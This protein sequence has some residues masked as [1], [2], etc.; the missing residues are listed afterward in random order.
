MTDAMLFDPPIG[1]A[2]T[3]AP[4]VRRI[5]APNPSPM[6]FRGTNTYLIG[7]G[8]VAVLD[9]GPADPRH[10]EAILAAA[11]RVSH[12]L[13]S[14]SHLDHSPLA[15]PLAEATGA[16]ILAYGPTGAGTSA[17]MAGLVD[18]G[19][20]EGVDPDFSPDEC[21]ADGAWVEGQGW[22]LQALWTPGHFGNHIAFGLGDLVFS[23]DLVMGWATTLISPPDG[24]LSDFYLSCARLRALAPERLLPGHGA[25]IEA[26]VSRID[27]LV[28]HRQTRSGQILNA[29]KAGPSRPAEITAR[30]YPD[31]SPTLRPA[32]ERNVLAHL[33]DLKRE[34]S[35]SVQGSLRP[36]AFFT[37]RASAEKFP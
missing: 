27:E 16:P 35:V 30:V 32:A 34:K 3:V 17:E 1:V 36:D 7:E 5:V 25:P 24:A 33:I 28:S 6:T 14:H 22:R 2:E 9:P 12:I 19:G 15:R 8:A 13:V 20:G 26:P 31:L 21:L 4:G 23:G 29:L 37:L 18:I 10:L 11:D